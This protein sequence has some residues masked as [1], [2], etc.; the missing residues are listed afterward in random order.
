M[1]TV[2][3]QDWNI[4]HIKNSSSYLQLMISSSCRLNKWQGMSWKKT[5]GGIHPWRTKKSL[6][7]TKS[8]ISPKTSRKKNTTSCNVSFQSMP[9]WGQGRG[10]AKRVHPNELV[11]QLAAVLTHHVSSRRC[12]EL[13]GLG[14]P[15]LVM[16]G[17]PRSGWRVN[18]WNPKSWR[19]GWKDAFPFPKG[20]KTQVPAVSFRGCKLWGHHPGFVT[21]WVL[22]YFL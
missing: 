20:W 15:V 13:R 8:G 1:L 10:P 9:R 19:F 14:V 6:W 7:E 18:G 4:L 3:L 21:K 16:T 22:G 5:C 12:A 11:K 2:I 17:G